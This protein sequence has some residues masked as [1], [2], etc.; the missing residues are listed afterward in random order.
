[1]PAACSGRQCQGSCVNARPSPRRFTDG[2]VPARRSSPQ[3]TISLLDPTREFADIDDRMGPLVNL[4]F[5]GMGL[6]QVVDAP[7]VPL[8]DISET[9]DAYMIQVDLPWV[10]RDQLNVE[11]NDREL[12]INVELV[13]EEHGRR[14]R[15][16]RRTGRFE[17]RP[18]LP[19]DINPDGITANLADGVLTVTVPKSE[20][21]KPRRIDVKS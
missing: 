12:V 14:R 5:D 10:S 18:T 15:R 13:D 17:F 6:T 4:A 16:L 11:L 21:A 7:W 1:M 3:R 20:A 19:R 9:D 8:A 2:T